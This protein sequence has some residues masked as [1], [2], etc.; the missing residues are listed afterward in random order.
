MRRILF[1][2]LSWKRRHQATFLWLVILLEALFWF[3]FFPVQP[4]SQ[5][6]WVYVVATLGLFIPVFFSFPL[7]AILKHWMGEVGW[8]LLVS[9]VAFESFDQFT[10]EPIFYGAILPAS[11]AVVGWSFLAW[12]IHRS[13]WMLREQ[14][15]R[16]TLTGL[17]NR[18]YFE[19]VIPRLLER[20]YRQREPFVFVFIDCDGLKDI[21]DTYSHEFGDSVLRLLG[22]AMREGSRQGDVLIRYGGDEFVLFLPRAS[23]EEAENIV[24]RIDGILQRKIQFLPRSF[25]F[26]A[27][28]VSWVPGQG[29]PEASALLERAD[30]AMY[31]VKRKRKLSLG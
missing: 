4:L 6:D 20:M 23:E 28:I 18:L 26:S 19:E 16:D 15:F 29:K 12:A 21:N 24:A 17:Y 9:G 31:E 2:V 1:A 11:C 8:M 30:T 7:V 13:F 5:W 25:G 3:I 10:T 27:G 14:S 22:E